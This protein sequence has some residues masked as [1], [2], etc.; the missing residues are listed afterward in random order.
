MDPVSFVHRVESGSYFHSSRKTGASNVDADT[1]VVPSPMRSARKLRP[2][3]FNAC[4][5]LKKG[6]GVGDCDGV[7]D[8]VPLT[9][10]VPD[11]DAVGVGVGDGEFEGVRVGD[12]VGDG[13]VETDT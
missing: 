12:C 11:G 4:A 10:G 8:G 7:A 6:D 9:V 5:P 3:A 1:A 13:V 2:S